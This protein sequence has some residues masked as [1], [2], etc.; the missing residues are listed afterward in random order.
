MFHKLLHHVEW[1]SGHLLKVFLVLL[2]LSWFQLVVVFWGLGTLAVLA[3]CLR[4]SF[5]SRDS[6]LRSRKRRER[7]SHKE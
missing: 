6:R 1:A 3:G 7:S 4:A 2:Q 5:V